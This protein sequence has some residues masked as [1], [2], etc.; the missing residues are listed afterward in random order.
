MKHGPAKTEQISSLSPRELGDSE[1]MSAEVCEFVI[2]KLV[3]IL[4]SDHHRFQDVT[5]PTVGKGPQTNRRFLPDTSSMLVDS[6]RKADRPD[7]AGKASQVSI[8]EAQ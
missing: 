7:A 6:A 3:E 4:V 8:K 1:G 5:R 2:A